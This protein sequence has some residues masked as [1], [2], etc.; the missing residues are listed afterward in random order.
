MVPPRKEL[1]TLEHY[2]VST[3]LQLELYRFPQIGKV[4]LALEDCFVV[5]NLWQT[6]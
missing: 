2:S 4:Y 1:E 6:L 3:G 5:V